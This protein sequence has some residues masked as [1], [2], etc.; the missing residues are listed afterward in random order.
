MGAPNRLGKQKH[1]IRGALIGRPGAKSN[2]IKVMMTLFLRGYNGLKTGVNN[3]IFWSEIGSEFGDPGG[4][5]P[6][7]IP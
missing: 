1:T 7:R 3:E 6:T 4:T 5:L 2:I